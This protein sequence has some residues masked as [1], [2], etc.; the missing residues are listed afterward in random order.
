M[1]HGFLS[2]APFFPVVFF[3]SAPENGVQRKETDHLPVEK[4]Y[5]LTR[6]MKLL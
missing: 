1:M 3:N 4:L 6:E 2:L 5:S